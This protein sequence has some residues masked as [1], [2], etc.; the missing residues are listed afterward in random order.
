[1]ALFLACYDYGMGGIWLYVDAES[2]ADVVKR[3]PDLTVA[4]H[5]P[6]WMGPE[7]EKKLRVEAGNAFWTKWLADLDAG[8]R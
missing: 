1:M 6:D 2:A 5:T 8:M 3:H 4:E 7:L